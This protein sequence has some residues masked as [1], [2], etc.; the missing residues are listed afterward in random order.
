LRTYIWQEHADTRLSD[1]G[2]QAEARSRGPTE[3]GNEDQGSVW[4]SHF[5]QE[6]SRH[7]TGP[8]NLARIIA[9]R[10]FQVE[11]KEGMEEL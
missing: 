2:G 3:G 9:S 1:T 7:Q 5:L 4:G 11:R 10:R 8:E 6:L